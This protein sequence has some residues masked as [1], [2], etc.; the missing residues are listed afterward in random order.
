MNPEFGGQ[1]P[2]EYLSAEEQRRI[3]SQSEQARRSLEA[4]EEG[5]DLLEKLK[6]IARMN[7]TEALPIFAINPG[8]E[9]E[10]TARFLAE[11]TKRLLGV[12][13]TPDFEET[14]ENGNIYTARKSRSN[15]EQLGRFSLEALTQKN[16]HES[17]YVAHP[18]EQRIARLRQKG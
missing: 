5:K 12:A 17:F 11:E 10:G 6:R 3:D 7:S 14:Y 9:D 1:K 2:P 13:E 18:F 8:D 15:L 16:G 4:T